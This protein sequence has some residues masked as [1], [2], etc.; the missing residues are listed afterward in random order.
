MDISQQPDIRMTTP[1]AETASS[2][3]RRFLPYLGRYRGRLLVAVF[4]LVGVSLALLSLG[5]GLAFIVDQGLGKGG[6][7]ELLDS[8]VLVMVGLA[9]FLGIGSYL[10]MAIVNDVAEKVMADIRN[11]IFVHLTHL[12]VSW[13]EAA[14]T[15]D[16]L[17]RINADTAILQTVMASTLVMA[18]RNVI[19]LC[20]GLVLV[21][22]S[23][24][25]MSI[26]V[27]VIVPIVVVPLLMLAR[28]LRVASRLAQERLG[29]VSAEAEEQLSNIRTVFAF[30]QEK[31]AANRFSARVESALQAGLARVRLRAA[32]SGFIIFMV[33]TAIT[34]ILWIGGRDLLAGKISAGDLSAF[35]FYAFLVAT[36]VGTLSELGGELQRASGAAERIAELLSQTVEPRHTT[37]L[38]AI[39]DDAELS[40]CFEDVSFSYPARPDIAVV[41]QLNLVA[42]PRQKIALVGQSGAGKSTLFHLLLGFYAPSSGRILVGGKDIAGLDIHTLR[43][44]IGLVPQDAMMFSTTI[45]QNIAFGRPDASSDE[46][47]QAARKAAAHDFITSLADG[48]DTMVGEKGVRLSGGQRQRIAIARAL[49]VNPQ[50]LLLDEAT[51]ALD[52]QHEQEIQSALDL[53]MQDRTSLVIAHRLSTVQDADLIVVMD[54]GTV[55]ATGTHD[56]LLADNPVYQALAMRQFS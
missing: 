53:V 1:P 26:V 56:R 54:K 9:L 4:I 50:I 13:F 28:R 2:A 6:N 18:V 55:L 39:D 33:I 31:T 41:S 35:I 23:S 17:A 30:A 48:Y 25:K 7:S 37:P 19:L 27:A 34:M 20:G 46:I 32:L 3:L 49:L 47:E 52:S 45:K 40:I 11:A 42:S 12:P 8:A 16:I 24:V 38:P 10:R 14:R 51:S 15:G 44:K 29:D 36:S 43:H 21:V 5:R 22:L